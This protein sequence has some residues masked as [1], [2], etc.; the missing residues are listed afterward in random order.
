MNTPPLDSQALLDHGEWIRRFARSLVRDV[1]VADDLVQETWLAALRARP[2]DDR[3]LRPWLA[4]VL[5]NFAV[6]RNRRERRA[7]FEPR[8]VDPEPDDLPSPEELLER[9]E[10]AARLVRAITALDE[11]YRSTVLLRYH[12]GLRSSEIARRQKLSPGTVRSRLKRG[13]DLVRER[14][15]REAGGREAWVVALLPWIGEGGLTQGVAMKLSTKIGIG[16][17]A[18]LLVGAGTSPFWLPAE[19]QPGQREARND[20]ALL[21]AEETAADEPVVIEERRIPERERVVAAAPA[22]AT[23]PAAPLAARWSGSLIDEETGEA[24]PHFQFEVRDGETTF[25]AITDEF[26][27][28][29]LEEELPAGMLEATWLDHPDVRRREPAKQAVKRTFPFDPAAPDAGDLE[30]EVGPTY[31]LEIVGPPNLQSED[32]L[33]AMVADRTWIEFL[34]STNSTPVRSSEYEWCRFAPLEDGLLP[35]EGPWNLEVRTRDGMLQGRAQVDSIV[36]V[37]DEVVRI[38]LADRG[39]LEGHVYE[40]DGSPTFRANVHVDGPDGWE[41]VIGT[42]EDGSFRINWM[43]PGEARITIV[44]HRDPD[45]VGTRTIEA[46]GVATLDV[47]LDPVASVGSVSGALKSRTGEYDGGVLVFLTPDDDSLRVKQV[48]PTWK[49][50]DGEKIARFEFDQLEDSEYTLTL[51]S[52]GDQHQWTPATLTIR[53]PA[54]DL[55]LVCEDDRETTTLVIHTRDARTGDVLPEFWISYAINGGL[56]RG[57]GSQKSGEPCL[58]QVTVGSQAEFLVEVEGYAIEYGS[59]ADAIVTDPGVRELTV[60]LRLGFGARYRVTSEDGEPLAGAQ[61]RFDGELV[62]ETGPD[63]VARVHAEEAPE[64]V[65]VVLAGHVVIEGDPS[66]VDAGTRALYHEIVMRPGDE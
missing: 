42:R 14:L 38:E 25:S 29:E 22:A 11:P 47:T 52:F 19:A 3:P 4:R 41:T 35:K 40:A 28:F 1:H 33:A 17:A 55:E 49:D 59:L 30:I 66:A 16:A 9:A 56:L 24:V 18:A 32:L 46:G 63:G 37:H 60:E 61:L 26:G 15:D 53:P 6:Q 34:R 62:G 21:V 27:N 50:V 54:T 58:E 2:D 64:S 13:L 48:A 5:R 8:E 44:H 65:E 43:P 7:P 12:E 10:Q 39:V 51:L 31:R 20:T 36:G 45:F 57:I 23:A